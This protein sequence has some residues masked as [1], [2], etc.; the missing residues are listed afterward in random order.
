MPL[1]GEGSCKRGDDEDL[2]VRKEVWKLRRRR[3]RL[4]R[5]NILADVKVVSFASGILL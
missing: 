2:V 5:E 3:G 1:D 4:F